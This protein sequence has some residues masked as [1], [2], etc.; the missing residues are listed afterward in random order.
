MAKTQKPAPKELT[1]E[2]RIQ[3]AYVKERGER[4]LMRENVPEVTEGFGL[5][6]GDFV[7]VGNLTDCVVI[8]LFEDG[9]F[10]V[11]EYTSVNNNYGRPIR[12]GGCIGCWVWTEVFPVKGITKSD[13]VNRNVLTLNFSN[14]D[15]SSVLWQA[16]KAQSNPD[17]QRGYVW[18]L[19]DKQKYIDSVF[20]QRSLG[21]FIFV[22][23]QHYNYEILDGKQ[24]LNALQEYV[25]GKFSYNGIYFREMSR[26]DRYR[27]M[28]RSVQWATVEKERL[29]KANLLKIFLDVNCAG[30]PQTEEHL[31]K[32]R[33]MYE[34]ELVK[35][36]I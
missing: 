35:D 16:S 4:T 3:A 8:G 23:D 25:A 36:T 22:K 34:D 21:A 26:V 1:S 18:T 28:S 9:K 2:E 13:V 19:E 30:V 6:L 27:F 7:E 5:E 29:T 15:L 32:I 12:T 10:V 11:I 20:E 33:K 24:R 31:A 14:S 17:Y